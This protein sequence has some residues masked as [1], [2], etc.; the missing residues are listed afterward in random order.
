MG[1]NEPGS[2][3]LVMTRSIP[4]TEPHLL[5]SCDDNGKPV[6]PDTDEN[7]ENTAEQPDIMNSQNLIGYVPFP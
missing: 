7:A 3:I 2:G 6:S 5:S 4:A 1:E